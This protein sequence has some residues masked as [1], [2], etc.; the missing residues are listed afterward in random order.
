M[1]KLSESLRDNRKLRIE[2][3]AQQLFIKQGFH[4]T[5]MRTIAARAGV[6]LGN[7]Y[8][9]YRTKEQILESIIGRYQK[10]IDA[11]LHDLFTKLDEP[12]RP[13]ELVSFGRAVRALVNEHKDYWLLMYIDV[14]E[15][16][17]QHFRKMFENLTKKLRKQFAAYFAKLKREGRLYEGTDPAVA[18]TA[19]YMQFFNYF[20]VE[21]LFGGRRHFG[22]SD[23]QVIAKLAEIYCRGVFRPEKTTSAAQR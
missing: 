14:L 23:E 15:F 1:P 7:V 12:F 10:V 2:K 20:L 21:K 19:A 18:F 9:Y 3:A 6:S 8:N 13:D 4:A 5:S 22:L 17:N 11:R 16:E